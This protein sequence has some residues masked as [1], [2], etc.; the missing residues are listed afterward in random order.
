MGFKIENQLAESNVNHE[1]VNNQK[2]WKVL[3]WM[4]KNLQEIWQIYENLRKNTRKLK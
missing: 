3:K 2:W 1:P 4:W